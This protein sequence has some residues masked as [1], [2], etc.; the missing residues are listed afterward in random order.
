MVLNLPLRV[1]DPLHV[2]AGGATSCPCESRVE[3]IAADELLIS[4]PTEA[5]TRISIRE[6]QI[7]TILYRYNQQAYEF[8]ATVID[9]LDDP[10]GLLA[11]RPSSLPR[12]IQRR[13]DIRMQVIA[14]VEL[15][16]KVVG[17]ARFKDTRTGSGH[18]STETLNICAGGFTI[19]HRLPID[20]GTMFG[21]RLDLPGEDCQPLTMSARVVR[22]SPL[23]E[24]E[25]QPTLFEWGLEF[26][27]ISEAS[28]ARIVRFIF[29][30]Q[31]EE[32]RQD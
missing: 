25:G 23:S 2:K 16:A 1:N 5:G 15:T 7:L 3:Q 30:A 6:H 21:A 27:R 11:V 4:W 17:L 8:E 20:V 29:G 10:I 22:C 13:N 14:P 31:R 24:A 18:I 9:M 32:R 19:R 28:R 26:T 12:G